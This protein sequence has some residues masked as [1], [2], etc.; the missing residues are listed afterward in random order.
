MS[1]SHQCLNSP[2]TLDWL[3]KRI[4]LELLMSGSC[5]DLVADNK[6]ASFLP[7]F[8][9]VEEHKSQLLKHEKKRSSFCL[10]LHPFY[11]LMI[12][13]M[14]IISSFEKPLCRKAY[15]RVFHLKINS[16]VNIWK[17]SWKATRCIVSGVKAAPIIFD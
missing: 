4:E 5:Q 2:F 8:L 1:M 17:K 3:L 12:W 14:Q 10:V 9:F 6:T 13:I 7:N 16:L 15:Y 11:Y